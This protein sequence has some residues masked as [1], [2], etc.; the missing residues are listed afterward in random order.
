VDQLA[1]MPSV[2][3]SGLLPHDA[4]VERY[5]RAHVAVD[6]MQPNAERQLAV[7]SRTVHYMWCGLPVI[8]AAFSEVAAVIREYEA[9]WVVRHDD[10]DGLR[11]VVTSIL[12][13]PAEAQR[14]GENAA[15]LARERFTWDV[16][17][18]ALDRFVR[19]PDL[20]SA[21]MSRATPLYASSAP[22]DPT[23]NVTIGGSTPQAGGQSSSRPD[24]ARKFQATHD[25]RRGVPAQVRARTRELLRS[26]KGAV[27]APLG[28]E[29]Q[30]PELVAGHSL[31][32]RFHVAE[33]G[34]SGVSVRVETFG[35]RNTSRLSL[36]L[37]DNPGAGS[38]IY[39]IALRAQT[40]SHGLVL[41][42]RF[43]PIRDW[44]GRSF[45]FL[46]V[47]P[48]GV[49]GDATSLRGT[50]RAGDLRAQRY[51]DGI[52]ASGYLVMSLEY[53]EVTEAGR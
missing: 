42:V 26:V 32:Q 17:V 44:A 31:G 10:P 4:L 53:N 22:A 46:A 1:T 41:T 50:S 36:R 29:V 13:D 43:P 51:D 8:H 49:P 12:A 33:N 5:T 37:R 27:G 47:S 23:R 45:Y 20:R 11:A 6:V 14:R 35:R 19:D 30:F 2:Q 24:F 28:L 40:L 38:D 25:R 34:L 9:G 52:P 21:R 39:H 3:M 7:P 16:T 48:D 18:D 15:R